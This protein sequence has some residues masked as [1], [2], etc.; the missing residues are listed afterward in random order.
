[1]IATETREITLVYIRDALTELLNRRPTADE[2]WEEYVDQGWADL[3]ERDAD[4]SS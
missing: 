2:V 3:E 4:A 1:M